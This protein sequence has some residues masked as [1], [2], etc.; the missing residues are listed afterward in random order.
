MID[1]TRLGLINEIDDRTGESVRMWDGVQCAPVES[2]VRARIELEAVRGHSDPQA[3]HYWSVAALIALEWCRAGNADAMSAERLHVHTVTALECEAYREQQQ[4]TRT[5]VW[6]SAAILVGLS[7]GDGSDRAAVMDVLRVWAVTEQ[8][9]RWAR[10]L[11]P[12]DGA[13]VVA[14]DPWSQ[15]GHLPGCA[16]GRAW[17]AHYRLEGRR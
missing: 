1:A 12:C 2:I 14:E 11:P 7:G 3:E 8:E 9:D 4:R 13:C 10:T 17:R 15:I 6:E 5:A 16:R